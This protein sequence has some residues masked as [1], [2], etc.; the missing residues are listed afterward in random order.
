MCTSDSV[1]AIIGQAVARFAENSFGLVFNLT[2]RLRHGNHGRRTYFPGQMPETRPSGR[3]EP[4]G[5]SAADR[6]GNHLVQ[7][8]FDELAPRR[9]ERWMPTRCERGGA[10][11]ITNNGF[12]DWGE[13][14]GDG[15][16]AS[17]ALDRRL[18]HGRAFSTHDE[19]HRPR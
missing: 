4:H 11:L 6:V 10:V 14:L 17:A 16:I 5:S 9:R 15:F 18:S 7:D 12:A 8:R 1:G 19:S 3:P 13:L 2:G